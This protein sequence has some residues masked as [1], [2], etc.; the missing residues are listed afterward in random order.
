[1]IGCKIRVTN[2]SCCEEAI[3]LFRIPTEAPR[4]GLLLHLLVALTSRDEPSLAGPVG[5][6]ISSFRHL[7]WPEHPIWIVAQQVPSVVIP[8][9]RAS[10]AYVLSHSFAAQQGKVVIA[11]P[12]LWA[13][14]T[15]L[16]A[17]IPSPS[18][19]LDVAQEG[20]LT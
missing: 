3:S 10:W 15:T 7:P 14:C 6:W 9:R 13:G 2:S 19:F 12:L 17:N 1:M 20:G 18:A 8:Q 5:L 4:A 11:R 16:D